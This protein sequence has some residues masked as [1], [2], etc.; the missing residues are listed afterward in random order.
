MLKRVFFA[1]KINPEQIPEVLTYQ[2]QI[3]ELFSEEVKWVSEENFHIT[4]HFLG[5]VKEEKITD[6]ISQAE[7]IKHPC[8]SI[9][10]LKADYFPP[11]KKRAKL[12]WVEGESKE[13]EKLNNKIKKE[14]SL[15]KDRP[16]FI[17]HITLGRIKQWALRKRPLEEV[18]DI[19]E[20]LSVTI[21]V[22][23]FYLVES[24]LKKTGAEYKELKMFPLQKNE[25]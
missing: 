25:H 23:R 6:I 7:K 3:K 16:S 10:F 22:D 19:K 1:I 9:N 14:F 20:D 21:N 11:D 12:I 17:P 13:A 24:V 2:K 18:P 4:L 8:F 15:D 5:S